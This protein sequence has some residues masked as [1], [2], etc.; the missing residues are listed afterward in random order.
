MNKVPVPEQALWLPD[1]RL[2]FSKLLLHAVQQILV[3]FPATAAVA[4]ITGFPVSTTLFSCGLATLCFVLITGKKVPL[5]FGSSFAYLS[6][7]I[8]LVSAQHFEPVGGVL[9]TEAVRVAQFG[10]LASGLVS[11]LA[12]VLV[13]L[14]GTKLVDRILPPHVTGAISIVIGLSL[15][16]NAMTD[17]APSGAG[18]W[19]YWLVALV[20]FLSA[21]LIANYGR[22]IAARL[23]LLLGALLG[24]VCAA[25]IYWTCGAEWNLFRSISDEAL[26]GG[27]WKLGSGSVFSLPRFSLPK[28]SLAALAAVMPMAFATIPESVAHVY[29][30]DIY[31][32]ALAEQKHPGKRYPIKELLGE[33]LIGDGIGDVLCGVIGAPAGTSYGEN[34]S[35]M[36]ISRVFSTS[37]LIAASLILMV[38]SCITPLIRVIYC[39]PSAVIGGLEIYLFG[40]I[41]VQGIA[42]LIQNRCDVFS[43]R[44]VAVIGSVMIIGLGGTCAFGG[45]IPFFGLQIPAI[46]GSAVF[47]ILLNLLLGLLPEKCPSDV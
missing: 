20:T 27:L 47:G 29:Q 25:V 19:Q 5:F 23:P 15:A 35:A 3:M 42:I 7:V 32:N 22:G 40:A 34:M 21:V 10:I 13:K 1:E 8:G 6:A 17:I 39:I 33:N 36:L 26:S 14:S 38:L 11:V 24:C 46:A 44:V 9:P 41:A 31:V 4:L 16:S 12:G 2:P 30:L 37:V 45:N 18:S 28:Y 43:T